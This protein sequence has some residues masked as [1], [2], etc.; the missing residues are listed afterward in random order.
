[1]RRREQDISGPGTELALTRAVAMSLLKLMAYKDEYEVARL[2][3]DGHF[4]RRLEQQF[5]GDVKLEYY[6]APPL[7]SRARDGKPPRKLRLGSWMGPAMKLLARGRVLR[8]T[9]LDIFGLTAERRME[10]SLAAQYVARIDELLETL[11]AQTL[12]LAT[13][14]A[15]VPLQMRGFGHV[16]IANVALAK[17]REAELLHRFDPERYPRPAATR[18]AGQLKGIRVTTEA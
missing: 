5:E 9:P 4:Q 14:I 10:R 3:S 6:M 17:T 13:E 12:P 1:V 18:G 15:L 11:S 2:Y 16:K 8:G 7:L